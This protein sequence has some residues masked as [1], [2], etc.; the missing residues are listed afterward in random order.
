MKFYN[1][2]GPNPQVVRIFAAERGVELD[3][4]EVDLMGGENRQAD[5]L[6]KNPGGQLPC[7]ELDD[8]SFVSEITAICEYIDELGD[9]PGLMGATAEDRARNRM[10]TRRVDLYI[11]EPLATAFRA[12]EGR[13]LFENRMTL[14]PAEV[15]PD[16]KAL[17]QEKITWLDGLMEGKEFIGGDQISLADILLF[18]FLA[19]GASVGQPLNEAN[20]NVTAWYERMQARPSAS[21]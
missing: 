13:A 18:C 8:G 7:L 3:M 1:S 11:C 21:A 19:F 16:L 5:Y 4:V 17:S 9:G 6:A 2:I 12:S 20:G 10:W 15:A 14:L